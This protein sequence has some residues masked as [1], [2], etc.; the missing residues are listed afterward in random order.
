LPAGFHLIH[1]FCQDAQQWL[2]A[3]PHNVIAVH[4]KA[5]KGRSG[6]MICA[7]LVFANAVPSAY[8]ALTWY[9]YTRGGR[10]SGVTIP[11][12]IRWVA[13]YERWRTL[14]QKGLTSN[15][16][17]APGPYQLLVVRLGPLHRDGT[18]GDEICVRI[19]LSTRDEACVGSVGF[20]YDDFQGQRDSKDEIEVFLAIH[21][22]Q[23]A[24]IEGLMT[25]RISGPRGQIKLKAWWNRAFLF[26]DLSFG[27]L[28]MDISKAWVDGLQKDMSRHQVVPENFRLKATFREIKGTIDTE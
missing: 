14:G 13:M 22:P 10:N 7:L 9:E 25:V 15:P 2:Q 27:L 21:G 24:D 11:A 20:W 1:E 28:V 12:Q 4:C 5:G 18:P 26:K 8:Q 19:G 3:D 23:W 17:K 16:M 6:T